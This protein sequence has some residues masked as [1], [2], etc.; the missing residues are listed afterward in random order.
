MGCVANSVSTNNMAV[1]G[2]E[3]GIMRIYEFMVTLKTLNI[4][5]HC[6]NGM[7]NSFF[8]TILGRKQNT[9]CHEHQ[10]FPWI[11]YTRFCGGFE[12]SWIKGSVRMGVEK[13]MWVFCVFLLTSNLMYYNILC[14]VISWRSH[15]V[16]FV[17]ESIHEMINQL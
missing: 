15:F 12:L 1:A 4:L 2:D 9:P 6:Q 11:V 10:I 7:H 13:K 16:D 3:R 8:F 17:V 14:I 5:V